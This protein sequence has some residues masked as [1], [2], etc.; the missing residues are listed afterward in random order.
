MSQ[1]FHQYLKK[2]C[3]LLSKK[4]IISMSESGTL[5]SVTKIFHIWYNI[6]LR[7]SISASVCGRGDELNIMTPTWS[8]N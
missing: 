8:L 5:G 4:D 3:E 2:L 6:E 7:L 1:K